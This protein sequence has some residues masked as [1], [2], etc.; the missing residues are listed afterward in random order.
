MSIGRTSVSVRGRTI[1]DSVVL[2]VNS[3]VFSGWT[4]VSINRR[5]NSVASSFNVTLTDRWT[6]NA[7]PIGIARGQSFCL[8]VGG[9]V[10]MN[11][12]ID[13]VASSISSSSRTIVVS[14]RSL[15]GDL[16]DCSYVGTSQ[17]RDNPTMQ[18]VVEK[19]LEPFNIKAIFNSD[20]GSFEKVDIRQG[21]KVAEVIDRMAREKNL[22]VYSD[23]DGNLVFD[24]NSSA[25]S[26]SEIHQGVNL[27]SATVERNNTDR[28]S[29]YIIKG[30]TSGII[31]N[32]ENATSN[33]GTATDSG[34]TR[35]RP[36]LLLGENSVNSSDAS[37]RAS[38][39]ADIRAAKSEIF[40]VTVQGWFQRDGSLW[41]I[42]KIVGLRSS[43]LDH[44]GD[45]LIDSV[46]FT[47]SNSGTFTDLS[48]VRPDAYQFLPAVPKSSDDG[49]VR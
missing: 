29:E 2:L 10:V 15:A 48:L 16:V 44:D 14:G 19:M 41:D 37:Q 25:R 8:Q 38:Y 42:N 31:G 7:R 33:T 40:N 23:F 9:R 35:Y 26:N 20:G 27:L 34:V 46:N 11:G 6:S 45:L 18:T 5:L 12:F 47:K 32:P 1:D 24:V 13:S 4:S 21:E 43:Y 3:Q 17:F 30:Q 49:I 39:E 28:F 36:L 22:I